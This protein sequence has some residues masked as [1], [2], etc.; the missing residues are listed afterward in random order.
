V[1]GRNFSIFS[2]DGTL[3][4]DAGAEL[5]LAVVAAGR[6]PDGRSDN[7]G[8]EPEG[9]EIARYLNHDFLFVG[10][11]R[12]ASVAVY[13]LTGNEANPV[14]VQ[15]LATGA[16]PEGLLAIPQRGL[17]VTANEG[18]GTISIFQGRPGNP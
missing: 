18:D 11:E 3:L 7:N 16:R 13:R 5:E 8:T 9:I 12:A 1:G 6:Y 17:F 10:M 4:F 15:V 2:P 14:F